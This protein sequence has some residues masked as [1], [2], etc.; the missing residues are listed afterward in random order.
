M[1]TASAGWGHPQD[2][3]VCLYRKY[4]KSLR[5]QMIP[6]AKASLPL[7]IDLFIV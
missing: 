2:A 6:D 4:K 5:I 7:I 3:V 1:K